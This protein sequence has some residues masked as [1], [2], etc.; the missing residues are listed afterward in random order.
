MV[1]HH[2]EGVYEQCYM[3]YMHAYVCA[4]QYAVVSVSCV[5]YG[6]EEAGNFGIGTQTGIV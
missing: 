5:L 6:Q 2:C 1:S 4:K 3:P